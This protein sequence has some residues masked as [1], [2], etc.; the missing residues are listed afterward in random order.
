M[1]AYNYEVLKQYFIYTDLNM[2]VETGSLW[3]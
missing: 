1:V 3:N 2:V